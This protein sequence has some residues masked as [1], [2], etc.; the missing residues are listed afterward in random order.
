MLRNILIN[1]FN[2]TIL[3]WHCMNMANFSVFLCASPHNLVPEPGNRW[4]H[5][6]TQKMNTIAGKMTSSFLKGN[7]TRYRNLPEKEMEKGKNL[8]SEAEQE[9]YEAKIFSKN[10]RVGRKTLRNWLN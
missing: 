2:L 5:W 1:V 8:I 10:V 6:I 9:E 3:M 4:K 7:T